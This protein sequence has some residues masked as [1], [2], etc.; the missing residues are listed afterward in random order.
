[1]GVE[2]TKVIEKLR[3]KLSNEQYNYAVLSVQLD[4]IAK[5]NEELKKKL[6]GAN[7]KD[8]HEDEQA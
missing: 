1:M 5:E 4:E 3:I 2:S 6:K 8:G 7:K